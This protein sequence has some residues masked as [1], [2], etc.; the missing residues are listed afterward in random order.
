MEHPFQ[1]WQLLF[2]SVGVHPGGGAP[3][4]DTKRET[5]VYCLQPCPC[6]AVR[7]MQTGA[8]Q[9][10][11]CIFCGYL[12][13]QRW[14]WAHEFTSISL[15]GSKLQ[16][17]WLKTHH[18]ALRKDS[19]AF[20][21][22]PICGNKRS[23][24]SFREVFA[25]VWG[26][27]WRLVKRNIHAHSKTSTNLS[28][29][30]YFFFSFFLGW[31]RMNSLVAALTFPFPVNVRVRLDADAIWQLSS[32]GGEKKERKKEKPNLRAFGHVPEHSFRT[33]SHATASS[34]GRVAMWQEEGTN[35][36]AELHR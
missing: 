2:P 12:G 14:V 35:S 33:C 21:S 16:T 29:S 30:T 24:S 11:L 32:P 34:R 36:L 6:S 20:P 22:Q 28:D 13:Q 5:V 1:T 8:K 23:K 26:L 25:S 9:F 7:S 18:I 15:M 4:F 31:N 3:S 27:K 19:A 17:L 10:P